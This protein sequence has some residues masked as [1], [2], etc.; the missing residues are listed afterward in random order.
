MI[1]M[2]VFEAVI[3]IAAVFLSGLM[4]GVIWSTRDDRER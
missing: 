2:P 1:E 3:T 4:F